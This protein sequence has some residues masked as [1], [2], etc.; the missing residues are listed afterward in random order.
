MRKLS[1]QELRHPVLY[2]AAKKLVASDFAPRS[3]V[4]AS[5]FLCVDANTVPCAGLRRESIFTRTY[6]STNYLSSFVNIMVVLMRGVGR[7][8]KEEKGN[9]YGMHCTKEETVARFCS[10]FHTKINHT[11]IKKKKKQHYCLTT[12]GN[13]TQR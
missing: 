13:Q 7:D 12:K 3:A 6:I 5:I 8:G 11:L 4:D 9:L 10:H 2:H 1:Y